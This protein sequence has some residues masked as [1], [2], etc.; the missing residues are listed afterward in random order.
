MQESIRT[1]EQLLI[2]VAGDISL[3]ASRVLCTSL[4]RAQFAAHYAHRVPDSYV[5]CHFFDLY[6]AHQARAATS[7][8]ESRLTIAVESDFST[9]PFD[10]VCLPLTARGDAELTRDLLQAGHQRMV[11]LGRMIV[12]TDHPADVWLHKE[13]KRLFDKVTRKPRGSGVAYLATKTNKRIKLKSFDSAFAIRDGERLIRAITRPGVFSHRRLD[14]GARALIETMEVRPGCRILELGCGCGIV[15]FAAA[16][17]FPDVQVVSLDSNPRAI[18]CTQRGAALNGITTVDA[19]LNA[20]ADGGQCGMFDLVLAN[21]PYYS[22]FRISEIFMRG[23]GQAL[24]EGGV[25]QIVTKRPDEYE[26]RVPDEFHSITIQS[27]RQYWIV[28]AVRGRRVP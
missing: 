3:S 28:R 21:P 13:M 20:D 17:R 10:A 12:T 19:R 9:E 27:A 26:S 1:S 16:L 11:E 6:A 22:H 18:E 24:K 7:E 4:G 8:V 15:S 14:V 2:D 5:R 25:L 23:A